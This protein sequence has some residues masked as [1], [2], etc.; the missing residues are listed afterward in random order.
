M[1]RV[2]KIAASADAISRALQVGATTLFALDPA[3]MPLI[4]QGIDQSLFVAEMGI[5]ALMELGLGEGACKKHIE[6]AALISPVNDTNKVLTMV[7]A[8]PPKGA[9]PCG[10]RE[11]G[12]VEC[13]MAINRVAPPSAFAFIRPYCEIGSSDVLV[14]PTSPTRRFITQLAK[15]DGFLSENT[16][17]YVNKPERPCVKRWLERLIASAQDLF[18]ETTPPPVNCAD[19][20]IHMLGQ[21]VEL[22]L[23]TPDLYVYRA[24]FHAQHPTLLRVGA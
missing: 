11:V 7:Q 24:A 9:K 5:E 18:Y 21:A 15:I 13:V 3:A 8:A 4:T 17:K 1:P 10:I 19:R 6:C 22:D 23:A 2:A 16:Q 12:F 20:A 14:N